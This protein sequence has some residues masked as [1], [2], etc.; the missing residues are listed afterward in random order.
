MNQVLTGI[1]RMF[2]TFPIG[3]I[4]Y[5]V[6]VIFTFGSAVFIVNGAFVFC[7]LVNAQSEFPGE[8]VQGGGYTAFIGATMF[9]VGGALLMSE[10]VNEDRSGSFG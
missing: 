8:V 6:A 9:L 2:T 1:L 5:L 7:S 4:S 10:A 3:D